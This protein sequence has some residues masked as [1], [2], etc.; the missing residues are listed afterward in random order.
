MPIAQCHSGIPAGLQQLMQDL[1]VVRIQTWLLTA[2]VP[3]L[4]LCT[5]ILQDDCRHAATIRD[6]RE[7]RKGGIVHHI[8]GMT[9]LLLR[10]TIGCEPQCPDKRGQC[11]PL[12]Q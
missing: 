8:A 6:L 9:L 7:P 3:L 4:I 10:S 2:S 1:P 12:D 11:Q 5:D